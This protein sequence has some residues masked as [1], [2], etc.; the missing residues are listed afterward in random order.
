MS[1]LTGRGGSEICHFSRY[2]PPPPTT[3]SRYGDV[4]PCTPSHPSPPDKI[5]SH[6]NI[7]E[8]NSL[9]DGRYEQFR[10]RTANGPT[11]MEFSSFFYKGI[12]YTLTQCK[13]N[14][15]TETGFYKELLLY[16][17]RRHKGNRNI[18]AM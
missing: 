10:K 5:H 4:L 2:T 8:F 17:R 16:E 18:I 14:F 11:P 1:S 15:T 3:K 6:R 9:D 12:S 7:F 13:Q